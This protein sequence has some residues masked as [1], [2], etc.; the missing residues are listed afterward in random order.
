M[1]ALVCAAE[2]LASATAHAINNHCTSDCSSDGAVTI[3]E[4]I[5]SVN[6]ALGSAS[7]MTCP[8]ADRDSDG[9]VE[10][11]ELITGVNKELVGCALLK[12]D[13]DVYNSTAA[14]VTLVGTRISGPSAGVGE[15]TTY[16]K[17]ISNVS[18]ASPTLGSPCNC[19]QAA[20]GFCRVVEDL[21]PGIWR[22]EICVDTTGGTCSSLTQQKQYRKGVLSEDA[23]A[24]AVLSWTAFRSVSTVST[25]NDS[26]TGSLR[27]AIIDANNA[28]APALVQFKRDVF[29]GTQTSTITMTG[30]SNL[31]LQGRYM[32]IDGTDPSGDP[33]PTD[34]WSNRT[35]R[36]QVVLTNTTANTAGG[37]FAFGMGATAVDHA[38]IVGL[39]ISRTLGSS[40]NDQD[41]V[42]FHGGANTKFNRLLTSR[43]DGGAGT[44][45]TGASGLDCI[46]S[47]DVTTVEGEA[48]VIDDT[49]VRHCRNMGIKSEKGYLQ[50]SRSWVHNNLRG[51][52]QA[53]LASGRIVTA[54]NLIESNGRNVNATP[55]DDN[56]NQIAAQGPGATPGPGTPTPT[57]AMLEVKTRGD[58][59]RL[60]VDSAIAARD[61]TK[62]TI[63]DTYVCG[64][65]GRSGGPAPTPNIGGNGIS[66]TVNS[67]S[68]PVSVR[69][70]TVVYN[71]GSGVQLEGTLSGNF[72][73]GDD[74]NA[75]A[76][77]NAFTRNVQNSSNSRA[78]FENNTPQGVLARRNEWEHC[79]NANTGCTTNISQDFPLDG[80]SS[81]VQYQPAQ[82]HRADPTLNNGRFPL[83][84]TSVSPRIISAGNQTVR[85][86]GLGFNAIEGHASGGNCL[87]TPAAENNCSTL[88]GTC[89]RADFGSGFTEVD[90]EAV[91]PTMVAFKWPTSQGLCTQP[92]DLEI[93]KNIASGM[94]TE[95]ECRRLDNQLCTNGPPILE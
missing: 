13:L 24:A 31:L 85:A 90:V 75:A 41:L 10:I 35:F 34:L 50:V 67:G 63:A 83:A 78:N 23:N 11:S 94:S 32:Q 33:S 20:G 51:G 46:E 38:E 42:V 61:N 56:A 18:C 47:S 49:E 22:H 82:P 80:H 81:P 74:S 48:N 28:S 25:L 29:T 19:P 91:T 57:P 53:L 68:Q 86:F 70:T 58:I 66:F 44:F 65:S 1:A 7:V 62:V 79:G 17:T 12:I 69:G 4:L 8:H 92:L 95:E 71:N 93:C 14:Q 2:M 36:R 54:E 39:A 5:K 88:K 30:S 43:L 89:V 6:I 26:G 52:L 45:S 73:F 87:T 64:M 27:Q 40:T 21:A 59:I 37:A 76:G 15:Q 72:D 16:T 84:V 9:D 60:G 77:N 3:D 55:V